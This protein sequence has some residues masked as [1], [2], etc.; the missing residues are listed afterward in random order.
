MYIKSITIFEKL[1]HIGLSKNTI[2]YHY[3]WFKN[4]MYASF[5]DGRQSDFY[6]IF[7]FMHDEFR[8][9]MA[10]ISKS[11]NFTHTDSYKMMI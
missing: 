11:N 9:Q 7:N 6:W 10:L 3:Q 4:L 8:V 5:L 2:L 1:C